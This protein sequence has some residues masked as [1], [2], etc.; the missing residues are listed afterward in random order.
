MTFSD[1]RLLTP[2]KRPAGGAVLN[3]SLIVGNWTN[4]Y[5][6]FTD[7][8]GKGMNSTPPPAVHPVA[9][10]FE[11]ALRPPGSETLF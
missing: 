1:K 5:S 4:K 9:V 10:E 8:F 7:Q 2:M 3:A 11:D 6:T